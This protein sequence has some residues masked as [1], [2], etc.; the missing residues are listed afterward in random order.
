MCTK[1]G[2]LRLEN[3]IAEIVAKYGNLQ[4]AASE[5]QHDGDLFAMGMSSYSAV[6]IMMAVEDRYDLRF[7][8][9]LL[10]KEYFSS[11]SRLAATVA[12]AQAESSAI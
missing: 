10:K 11:V 12:L 4:V 9:E 3:E 5:I 7:R 8:D 6:Q 2:G 1:S